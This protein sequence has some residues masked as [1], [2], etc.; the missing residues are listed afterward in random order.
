MRER[1][2]RERERERERHTHTHTHRTTAYSEPGGPGRSKHKRVKVTQPTSP[3]APS[4]AVFKGRQVVPI[5]V[6]FIGLL[7]S[8]QEHRGWCWLADTEYLLGLVNR[9]QRRKEEEEEERE[10]YRKRDRLID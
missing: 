7:L 8:P 4:S 9:E 5:T 2:E 3:E 1:R 6:Y 10:S